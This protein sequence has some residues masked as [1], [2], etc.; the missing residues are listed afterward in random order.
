M[1]KVIESYDGIYG[2]PTLQ[3]HTYL[4]LMF[5][6]FGLEFKCSRF[7]NINHTI[8][9]EDALLTSLIPSIGFML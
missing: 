1:H 2:F 9:V 6:Q 4:M 7:R 5:K 8:F 3:I